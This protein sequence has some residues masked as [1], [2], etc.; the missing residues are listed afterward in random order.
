MTG[1]EPVVSG[2]SESSAIDT[3]E[4]T[5]TGTGTGTGKM[6]TDDGAIRLGIESNIG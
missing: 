6:A 5:E 4:E 1:V 2:G 3:A